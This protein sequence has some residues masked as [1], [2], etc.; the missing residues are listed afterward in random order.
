[1]L[2]GWVFAAAAA[3]AAAST[4]EMCGVWG[5][6]TAGSEVDVDSVT[7]L[8]NLTPSETWDV[9]EGTD[10]MLEHEYWLLFMPPIVRHDSRS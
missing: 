3:M 9:A 4:W 7:N 2:T 1:M 8:R 5:G 6:A 10:L